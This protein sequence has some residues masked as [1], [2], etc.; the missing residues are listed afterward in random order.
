MKYEL[1]SDA[2]CS[3]LQAVSTVWAGQAVYS[4]AI[5]EN[6]WSVDHAMQIQP[7]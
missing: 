2:V 1:G 4:A 5:K 7:Q 3:A 6:C